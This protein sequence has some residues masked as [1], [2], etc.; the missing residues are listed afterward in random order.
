MI[1]PALQ[2]QGGK[3]ESSRSWRAEEEISDIVDDVG[4]YFLRPVVGQ[5]SKKGI[6]PTFVRDS[7]RR[8]KGVAQCQ[9][10][11]GDGLAVFFEAQ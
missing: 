4:I 11:F 1:S 6:D 9:V 7:P 5:P 2:I 8:K 10:A 3:V